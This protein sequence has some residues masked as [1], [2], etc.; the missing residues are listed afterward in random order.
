MYEHFKRDPR[1]NVQIATV[2]FK[3]MEDAIE[4]IA[5]HVENTSAGN[6]AL[7]ISLISI[8]E[9]NVDYGLV[10]T[11]LFLSFQFK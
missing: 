7:Q 2:G 6:V 9:N 1:N 3:R 10:K 8:L 11:N 4:C 5:D